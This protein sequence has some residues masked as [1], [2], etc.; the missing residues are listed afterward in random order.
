[1]TN[2]WRLTSLSGG[3]IRTLWQGLSYGA[4][5]LLRNDVFMLIAAL[6][7]ALVIG[8]NTANFSATPGPL[9]SSESERLMTRMA[10][11]QSLPSPSSGSQDERYRTR[12]SDCRHEPPPG[13]ALAVQKSDTG[14]KIHGY[15]AERVMTQIAD[16]AGL[17]GGELV[18]CSEY[19]RVE[20]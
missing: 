16:V 5:M 10:A 2:I 11:L 13:K 17:E 9:V 8:A 15:R 19:G 3:I 4:Q 20:I 18:V 7:L 6:M 12:P 1:P 14:I